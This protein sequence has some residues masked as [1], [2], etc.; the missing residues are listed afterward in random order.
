MAA[1]KSN[2]IPWVG[3]GVALIVVFGGA[4]SKWAGANFIISAVGI[5][6]FM[7]SLGTIT[8]RHPLGILISDRNLM[9][10]SRFQMALWTVIILGGYLTI[11]MGRLKGGVEDPLLVG[12]HWQ[13]WALMG[14]STASL[15]GSPMALDTKKDQEPREGTVAKVA[16]ESEEEAKE[17]EK[18]REG[19][20]YKNPSISDASFSDIFEGDEVQNTKYLD[21]AK[22]QMFLFTIVAAGVYAVT[23]WQTLRLA[24]DAPAGIE[25]MPMVS[26]GLVALLGISH[27]GYLTSKRINHTKTT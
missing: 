8:Y 20:L 25:Q 5:A 7:V 10:L 21:L 22:V 12:M 14:I 4:A 3:A 18:N 19:V 15:I 24:K 6:G 1:N 17:I 13:L 9:S 27:A 11:V 2:F 23:L 16:G 26:D